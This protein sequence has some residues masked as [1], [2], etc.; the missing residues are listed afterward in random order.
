MTAIPPITRKSAPRGLLDTSMWTAISTEGLPDEVRDQ[1]DHWQSVMTAYACGNP[2]ALL[3]KDYGFSHRELLRKFNKCIQVADDGRLAGWRGILPNAMRKPY[4]RQAVVSATGNSAGALHQLF[5]RIGGLEQYLEALVLKMPIPEHV[6]EVRIS[7]QDVHAAFIKRCIEVGVEA[8]QWPFNARWKG[9]RSIDA[10]VA[11]VVATRGMRAVA[12]RY[13]ELAASK[14]CTG[15]G[16]NRILLAMAPLD[17]AEMDAHRL[18]LIGVIG[19]PTAEGV[20]WVPIERLMLLLICDGMEGTIL[21]YYAIVRRE[22]NGDDILAAAMPMVKPWVPRKLE[23]GMEYAPGSGLPFGTI[24]GFRPYGFCA[25]LVDNALINYSWAV[26]DRLVRR[27][28]CA[29]NWGPVRK[30][31]RRPVIE[32]IFG[33]LEQAGFQRVVSSTGSHP[34][35]PRRSD[36]VAAAVKHRVHLKLVLDLID[37]VIARFNAKTSEGRFGMSALD[38][39]RDLTDPRNGRTIFPLLPPPTPLAPELDVLVIRARITGSIA[40][41][42]RPRIKYQRAYYT[43]P[44]IAQSPKLSGEKVLL[45]VRPNDIRIVDVFLTETGASLGSVTVTGKW[46]HHAHSLEMRRQINRCIDDGRLV[47]DGKFDP[48]TAMHRLLHKEATKRKNKSSRKT[49]SKAATDLAREAVVTGI[50]AGSLAQKAPTSA[51]RDVVSRRAPRLVH[52]VGGNRSD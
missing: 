24:D 30:W 35:D 32:R 6:H 14:M 13:G 52:R 27:I 45:H 7:N 47:L 48:V 39:L 15:T 49:V 18:D 25:L 29:V 33:A 3:L 31:M 1:I 26:T 16:K 21:G 34:K 42:R 51:P 46:R 20:M 38:T 50:A 17:V 4:V 11:N 37:L 19:L 8:S 9:R 10:F 40:K 41:G 36:P 22:C 43:S 12:A 23:E 2:V 44:I 5:K 28:G